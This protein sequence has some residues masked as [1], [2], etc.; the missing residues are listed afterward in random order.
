MKRLSSN[1][2]LDSFSKPVAEQLE[3]MFFMHQHQYASSEKVLTA[4]VTAKMKELNLEVGSG[5]TL[6]MKAGGYDSVVLFMGMV[7]DAENPT[8]LAKINFE[9]N[10]NILSFSTSLKGVTRNFD[11]FEKVIEF[12]LKSVIRRN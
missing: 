8:A 3:L 9:I 5:K 11:S 10:E 7:G 2:L 4:A 1:N 12:V 6:F